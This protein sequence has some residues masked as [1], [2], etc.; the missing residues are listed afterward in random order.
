MSNETTKEAREV[1]Q[2][3]VELA[4]AH[5]QGH[6]LICGD[7]REDI[8]AALEEE[9]GIDESGGVLTQE[10]LNRIRGEAATIEE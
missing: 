7:D 1:V 9:Y 3:G 4:D 5:G 6:I 8:M 2:E 10:D